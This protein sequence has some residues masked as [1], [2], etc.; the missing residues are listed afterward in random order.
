MIVVDG[1][2]AFPPELRPTAVTIGKFDGLHA[3]HRVL[4]EQLHLEAEWASLRPVVVTFDR[5]PA[6]LV[7]PERAPAPIL[8]L[9]QKL[10]LLSTQRLDACVVLRFDEALARLAPIEFVRDLLVRDLG[11]K[12]LIVGS[13]FRFGHRGAG[14]VDFLRAHADEYGYRVVVPDD[15]CGP[16]G[17]RRASSTWV[18]E[19]LAAGDVAMVAELLGRYHWLRGTVVHGAKRGRE[20]GFPTAN[21]DPVG[22]EGLIPADGVYA[23]WFDDGERNYPAAI[24]VGDNPT[25][26][27]V[28]QRQV[29]AHLIDEHLD[30]YGKRVEVAFVERIRG[31]E[32]F[33]SI[34]ELV[35]RMGRDVEE[36]RELLLGRPFRLGEG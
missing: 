9:D 16:D 18:R 14:D 35:A 1:T 15:E 32:K 3:G 25:F 36:S 10:E 27:G 5:H 26:D 30:L 12:L 6:A 2:A 21:L 4:L 8:S 11:A 28:P 20:L 13:D 19:A 17:A 23:G 22:L 34:D 24:S 33:A 31:M 7:A 29:E